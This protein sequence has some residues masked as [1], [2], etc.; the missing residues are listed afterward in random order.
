MCESLRPFDDD[1][2]I[3]AYGFGD[4]NTTNRSVFPFLTFE[5]PCYGLEGVL[6][7]YN[8]IA[9]RVQMSG[10]T[11][12]APIIKQAIKL[13]SDRKSYHIL[14]IIADGGVTDMKE[15]IQAIVEASKHPLSIICIGVGSGPWDKMIKMDDNIPKR[16]FDNFQFV[17][18]HKIMHQCE[19][20]PI[21]FA[22]NALMEI[23]EQY[24]YIK[25]HMF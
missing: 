14:I 17:D 1:Q 9:S 12:F 15:T 3:D 24:N 16:K 5:T 23:P 7:C 6:D 10:P 25:N 2:L 21:E 22:R 11:S 13:V 18:F 19:N 20:E 4:I 8:K